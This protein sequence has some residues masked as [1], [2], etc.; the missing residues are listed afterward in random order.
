MVPVGDLGPQGLIPLFLFHRWR[1]DALDL[2][3][4]RLGLERGPV[5]AFERA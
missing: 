5:G 4:V 2:V 3:F 1:R